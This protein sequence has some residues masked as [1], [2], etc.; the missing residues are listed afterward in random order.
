[1]DITLAFSLRRNETTIPV[2]SPPSF[3]PLPTILLIFC[4]GHSNLQK[5]FRCTESSHTMP[6]I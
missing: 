4:A 5:L 6:G 3:H 2:A 1:M